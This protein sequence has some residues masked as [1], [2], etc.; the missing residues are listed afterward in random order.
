MI[1]KAYKTEL[2]L[3]NKQK[4]FFNQCFGATRFV[5]NW[6]LAEWK[7]QYEAGEKPSRYGLCKQFNA[8]KDNF[9]PW[10]RE[11]PYAVTEA[12]FEGLGKAFD[13]FFRRVKNG[14]KQAGYP[15]FKKRG[16]KSSARF[17]STLVEN[18][19]VRITGVGWVRLKQVGYIPTVERERYT[20]YATV[21]ERAGKYFISIQVEQPDNFVTNREG[22]IGVDVGIKS[23]AVCSDGTVYENPKA[24]RRYEARL[25]RIQRELSRRK[26]GGS[27]YKKT[28]TKLARMHYKI[29]CIRTDALHNASTSIVSKLPEI[30][31]TEDLNIAGMKK[32]HHLAKAVSD[33]SM[34]EFTRQIN[35]KASWAGIEVIKADRFYPSSKTCSNCGYVKSWLSLNER[36][37]KCDNCGFELDRDLN[38][39]IN[40]AALVNQKVETQPDCLG[41]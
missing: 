25:K 26:K 37:Y 3:N 20:L 29:D 34:S 2:D 18:N 8:E 9:A 33:V 15:K 41:S 4:T 11:I 10:I 6:G 5:Y 24:L 1:I 40:L 17:R 23:L 39:A 21:S 14:D 38:A 22:V 27:N 28:K 12:A 31:V 13:N 35:Y 30:I 19:R 36:V 7:R 32:N 16:M